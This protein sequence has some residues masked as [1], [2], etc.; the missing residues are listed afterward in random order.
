MLTELPFYEIDT[1]WLGSESEDYEADDNDQD[2]E[3]IL[4]QAKL[5]DQEEVEVSPMEAAF[6]V[7]D[8]DHR[9]ED[10]R[11]AAEEE[12][13]IKQ[14]EVQPATNQCMTDFFTHSHPKLDEIE[15]EV[16]GETEYGV[17]AEELP[18][19]YYDN[20]D[21]YYDNYLRH[22]H[23]RAEEAGMVTNRLYFHH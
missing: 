21:G 23:N 18:L 9:L 16:V 10:M 3:S 6:K 11:K 15:A 4:R 5:N 17:K 1:D 22:K 20:D 13:D 8:E 2:A 12:L 19:N 7:M 14:Y